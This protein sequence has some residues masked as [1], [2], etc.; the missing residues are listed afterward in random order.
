MVTLSRSWIL[1][2]FRVCCQSPVRLAHRIGGN[3]IK[4]DRQSTFSRPLDRFHPLTKK[5]KDHDSLRREPR[6][7]TAWR[8]HDS[9]LWFAFQDLPHYGNFFPNPRQRG[10]YPDR[11]DETKGRYEV[12]QY[13]PKWRLLTKIPNPH[14]ANTFVPAYER[15]WRRSADVAPTDIAHVLTTI[16]HWYSVGIKP[17]N[18][19]S[20]A[21]QLLPRSS[22]RQAIILCMHYKSHCMGMGIP[23]DEEYFEFV[24]QFLLE[25]GNSLRMMEIHVICTGFFFSQ[26]PFSLPGV[27][28]IVAKRFFELLLTKMYPWSSESHSIFKQLKLDSHRDP[29][30]MR[31][32]AP[33][34]D[35]AGFFEFCSRKTFNG[36]HDVH[37]LLEYLSARS[38]HDENHLRK[39][40]DIFR[41]SVGLGVFTEMRSKDVSRAL[42]HFANLNYRPDEDILE[43]CLGYFRSLTVPEMKETFGISVLNFLDAC[44]LFGIYPFDI[45][46]AFFS[47]DLVVV[48]R[49]SLPAM[50]GDS[51]ISNPWIHLFI[52]DEVVG[53]ACP[54]YEGARLPGK[55]KTLAEFS[56]RDSY[57]DMETVEA[58]R[59]SLN[60]AISIGSKKKGNFVRLD[61]LVKAKQLPDLTIH[62]DKNNNALPCD[63]RQKPARKVAVQVTCP[64]HY[65]EDSGGV[66]DWA[67]KPTM[68]RAIDCVARLG[69]DVHVVSFLDIKFC[70]DSDALASD[71]WS[72]VRRPSKTGPLRV[73]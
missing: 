50:R 38:Y 40:C 14:Y 56:L 28:S 21:L 24:E 2:L 26:K 6:W 18:L 37:F 7:T 72:R 22:S 51:N 64:D 71:V 23:R 67:L 57:S 5:I 44:S 36:L 66:V 19:V 65:L 41:R 59:L 68:R 12:D 17:L 69:Y 29:E 60:K 1:R 70:N 3:S 58:V 45:I 10:K 13:L 61:R 52:Y 31:L 16:A 73:S 63:S 4:R 42:L 43:A 30:E 54:S 53:I 25:N 39:C 48:V 27:S 20:E 32:L 33:A 11:D 34:L 47:S 55:T 46:D 49:D 35:A 9:N 15:F 8:D 62:L